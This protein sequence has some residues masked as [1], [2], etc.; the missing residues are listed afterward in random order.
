MKLDKNIELLKN[1]IHLYAVDTSALYTPEERK[2][3]DKMQVLYYERTKLKDENIDSNQPLI[4]NINHKLSEHK[5]TLKDLI[6]KNFEIRTMV[7]V[8]ELPKYKAIKNQ[9]IVDKDIISMFESSLSRII[10]AEVNEF[11]DKLIIV[12]TFFT[13][14][15]EDIIRDGFV[16]N[17]EKYVYFAASSGQIRKKLNIFIKESVY[18]EHESTLLCGLSISKINDAG[19][20]C[21]NK[22]IAYLALLNS[23]TVLWNDFDMRKCIV[24]DDFETEVDGYVDYIDWDN[25][26]EV[27]RIYKS[28]KIPHTDGLGLILPSLSKK[29]IVIRSHFIKGLL[30]PFDF[31]KFISKF[32]GN[33]VIK[34]IYGQEHNIIEDDIQIIFTKSQFKLWNMYNDWN[35]YCTKY[36]ENNCQTGITGEDADWFHNKTFNYQML[37]TL[38]D[39]STDD[40]LLLVTKNNS[41]IKQ[42]GNDMDTTLRVLGLVDSNKNLNMYDKC[43]LTDYS[44]INSYY[45]REMLKDIKHQLIRDA[46]SGKLKFG[47]KYTYMVSDI[48]A[49]AEWLFLGID[50]PN[51][52]IGK[53]QVF[54]NLYSNNEEIDVLRSPHLSIEHIVRKN[55]RNASIHE[56]FITDGIYMSTHNKDSMVLFCDYDG[57]IALTCNNPIIIRNAKR[58][59]ENHSIVPLDFERKK[60]ISESINN[61]TIYKSLM[62]AYRSAKIGQ[63]SNYITKLFNKGWVTE[64]D[65]TT[66]KVLVAVVNRVIDSAKNQDNVVLP[67]KYKKILSNISRQPPPYFFRHVKY[68]ITNSGRKRNKVNTMPYVDSVCNRLD[69]IIVNAR[70]NFADDVFGKFDYHI[71]M[72]N[73]NTQLE[74]DDEEYNQLVSDIITKY[75]EI[76]SDIRKSFIIRKNSK[77]YDVYS[78]IYLNAQ[79]QIDNVCSDT[80]FVVDVLIEYLFGVV[81]KCRKAIFW[82]CWGDIVESNMKKNKDMENHS[83]CLRCNK[84]Y[85]KNSNRQIYC[86]ECGKEA[87]KE[88]WVK[89]QYNRIGDKT[90]ICK[91]CGEEFSIVATSRRKLCDKCKT[92]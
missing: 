87:K 85:V 43:L 64:Q 3:H 45:T 32:N 92:V 7:R 57:D 6:D 38:Y 81:K 34:D 4:R 54:C 53:D 63:Y 58:L 76:Q 65:L 68:K 84:Y 5:K 49:F 70:F 48:F 25:D 2:I 20:L 24:V 82:S 89:K 80:Y 91:N 66:I 30:T 67:D 17:N 27:S 9:N 23:A 1:Q 44:L 15:L 21:V 74:T 29:N 60:A 37:Q 71:L 35:D 46:K 22:F 62:A 86:A 28:N 79:Q 12:E 90:I 73:K 52:L 78:A 41:D 51:G 33:S 42:I 31:V 11:T 69:K 56:W 19:G 77:D 36:E 8:S 75:E 55:I 13:G 47:S 40:L 39:M 10:G 26:C 18:K 16:Y 59:V 88:Q 83:Q 50:N 14:V 72:N 61:E